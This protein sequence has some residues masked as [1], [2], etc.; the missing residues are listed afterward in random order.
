MI[1]KNKEA[2]LISDVQGA[3]T[4]A[5]V[6]GH[7]EKLILGT[8]QGLS[9]MEKIN[10]RWQYRYHFEGFDESSRVLE[11]DENGQLWMAHGYKGIYKI[12]FD[13]NY[14][15]IEKVDFYNSEKGFPSDLLIGM[16]K[17]RNELL[18]PAETGIYTY[19]TKTDRFVLD[20]R[21]AK[22]FSPSENIIKIKEDVL[23]NIYFMSNQRIGVLRFDNFGQ[24][25][26][27]TDIF[28]KIQKYLNDDLANI[29]II[30]PKNILFGAKEGFIHYDPDKKKELKSFQTHIRRITNTS[31]GDSILYYGKVDP[32]PADFHYA[33]NSLRFGFS[34]TFY[35]DPKAT[36]YQ[37][38]LENFDKDWSEWTAT[39]EKEYTNL[40]E[41]SYTFKVR[42]KNIYGTLSNVASFEFIV[43][44]PFYRSKF[45][46]LFYTVGGLILFG[47]AYFYLDKR[48]NKEKK[49]I[50]LK[51][52]RVLNQKD[53]EIK[54]ITNKSEEAIM[55][56]SNEKLQ[57]EIEHKNKEL[58]SSTIHLI[59]KN[60]LLSSVKSRLEDMVKRNYSGK[61][62]LKR[63]IKEMEQNISS[64]KDWNQFETHFNTV[65]GDFTHRLLE[66]YPQL[67]PQEIKLSAYLRLNLNT[68]EI[69]HLLN[70]SVRG[71]EISRYRLRK[72]L[73]LDR[74]DNLTDFML[75]F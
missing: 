34:A 72:K 15:Q 62:E 42:S 32:I 33:E 12:Q 60:E 74:N 4:F 52:E 70:I 69:A 3:W 45:A 68:K 59:N 26:L 51:Q 6:P 57:S 30:D 14:Q 73:D 20:E 46:Y 65:H 66:K 7:P 36:Q 10:G 13:P 5:Q 48:F 67:T 27:T 58:T 24:A 71:V 39:T 31:N 64:D 16:E 75:R 53:T 2:Q 35:E 9:L 40:P 37:W 61:D 47:M 49:M 41:G 21:Y 43:R 28:N 63:L 23:G 11:F 22:I 19:D 55:R 1:L 38:I 44:P 18:F 29:S 56:L 54:Q 8:Y 50:M 25:T 17:I